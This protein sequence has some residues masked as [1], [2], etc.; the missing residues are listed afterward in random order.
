T[1][2]QSASDTSRLGPNAALIGRP[3]SRNHL[4]TPCLVLDLPALKRNVSK[5]ADL[6]RKAGLALRPHAKS[7]KSARIAALQIEAGAEG[8]CVA[9]IGEAEQLARAGVRKM[10]ITSSVS[11]PSKFERI[12][13]LAVQGI[14]IAAVADDPVTV[15]GL[16][17]ACRAAGTSI[18]A[19]I[20]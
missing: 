12:A 9:T 11:Q 10:L 8:V 6:A 7:H 15:S 16:A 13:R 3:G 5:G 4:A 17:L 14:K 19:M 2:Q 20:D 18:D 1:V